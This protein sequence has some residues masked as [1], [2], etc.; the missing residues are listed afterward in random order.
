MGL[1]I[2][3]K[4]VIEYYNLVKKDFQ[5]L[6]FQYPFST[7]FLPPTVYP[8]EATLKVIAAHRD[9]INEIGAVE[10]D[11]IGDFSKE[12]YIVI[13]FDY[14]TKGCKVYGAK[15]LDKKRFRDRDIHFY[16]EKFLKDYGYEF[17]V[18]VPES[19]VKMEN[20][21]LENVRTADMMLIAYKDYMSG[22]TNKLNLK[23]YSHGRVG[24]KEYNTDR[25]RFV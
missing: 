18:G 10:A 22:K 23:A 5:G 3:D 11:F 20:V 1:R 15:W 24:E 16:P 21:L 17:C 12:L 2:L 8:C 4:K 7:L 25:K 9:L 19:F 13:P 14:K 6:K